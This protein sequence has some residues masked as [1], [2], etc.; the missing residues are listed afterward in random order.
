MADTKTIVGRGLALLFCVTLGSFAG[1]GIW[2]L[3]LHGDVP[4]LVS[5]VAPRALGEANPLG[6]YRDI[7]IIRAATVKTLVF[8][9]VA[10]QLQ[11]IPGPGSLMK[12]VHVL[13]NQ[14]EVLEAVLQFGDGKVARV[15]LY[16]ADQLPPPVIPFPNRPRICSKRL[17]GRQFLGPILAPQ[18]FG[19]SESRHPGLGRYAG[20]GENRASPAIDQSVY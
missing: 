1:V 6:V 2:T 20:S 11:N 9:D 17:C 4:P 5:A 16:F 18:A 8:I 15:G 14:H 10:V 3:Y 19:A 13:C 12:T 7:D